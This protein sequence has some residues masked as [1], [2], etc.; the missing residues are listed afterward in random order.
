M[1]AEIPGVVC[2]NSQRV[3]L[4]PE[5]FLGPHRDP[6]PRYP[7]SDVDHCFGETRRAWLRANVAILAGHRARRRLPRR[8]RLP[9]LVGGTPVSTRGAARW[10]ATVVNGFGAGQTV[11]FGGSSPVSRYR[12]TWARMQSLRG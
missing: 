4:D 3:G 10:S 1:F 5:P 11:P 9:G 6:P 7:P 8:Q 2:V 12:L